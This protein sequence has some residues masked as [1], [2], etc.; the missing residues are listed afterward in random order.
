MNTY[1]AD[2]Y[3]EGWVQEKEIREGHPVELPERQ[4]NITIDVTVM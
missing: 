1:N 3:Y 4:I 2:I